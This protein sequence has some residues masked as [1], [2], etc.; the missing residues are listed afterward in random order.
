LLAKAGETGECQ[1]LASHLRTN[2]RKGDTFLEGKK[3]KIKRSGA[4]EKK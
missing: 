1:N 4:L 2:K 3:K